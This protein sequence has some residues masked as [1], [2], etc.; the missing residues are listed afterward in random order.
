MMFYKILSML[1]LVCLMACS[2]G[3]EQTTQTKNTTQQI[4]NLE[5]TRIKG[6]KYITGMPIRSL[7]WQPAFLIDPSFDRQFDSNQRQRLRTD[8]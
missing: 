4:Q 6:K 2:P 5:S 8:G 3:I 7:L 1:S